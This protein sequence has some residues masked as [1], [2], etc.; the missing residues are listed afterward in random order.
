MISLWHQFS[1]GHAQARDELLLLPVEQRTESAS[2]CRSRS[3]WNAQIAKE[4]Q[5]IRHFART[6]LEI[7]EEQVAEEAR[8]G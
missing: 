3:N 5:S 2:N 4:V 8:D 6:D 1:S 7:N